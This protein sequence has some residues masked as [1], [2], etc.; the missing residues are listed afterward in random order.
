M[1]QRTCG[2]GEVVARAALHRDSAATCT[3]C[4]QVFQYCVSDDGVSSPPRSVS[5]LV[6]DDTHVAVSVGAETCFVACLYCA[7]MQHVCRLRL[8]RASILAPVAAQPTQSATQRTIVQAH[9][10]VRKRRRGALCGSF[11]RHS[12][13]AR[14]RCLPYAKDARRSNV[15]DTILDRVSAS[16]A[17][18]DGYIQVE[19]EGRRGAAPDK[20]PSSSQH[21]TEAT[22]TRVTELGT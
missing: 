7:H 11:E 6:S 3:H 21:T 14:R 16:S 10:I 15:Q 2:R 5:P 4:A 18:G 19:Q 8:R 17:H 20:T 13:A 12:G 22:S 1:F 9:D